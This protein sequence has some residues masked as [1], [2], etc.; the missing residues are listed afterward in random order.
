VQAPLIEIGLDD[1]V[2]LSL[3]QLPPRRDDHPEPRPKPEFFDH[4]ESVRLD[5]DPEVEMHFVGPLFRE[6]GYGEEHE[7][8]GF[9]FDMWEGVHHHT[10]EADLLYFAD[11]RHRLTNDEPA[12]S[13]TAKSGALRQLLPTPRRPCSRCR[14][15][16][17]WGPPHLPPYYPGASSTVTIRRLLR[18]QLRTKRNLL[19]GSDINVVI[20]LVS[21]LAYTGADFDRCAG[22]RHLEF[23][24]N[25]CLQLPS[26]SLHRWARVPHVGCLLMSGLPVPCSRT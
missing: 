13:G 7:G 21:N 22:A 8:A 9:P 12:A 20:E 16:R 6:L 15:W 19:P 3:T 14:S 10:A 25:G 26:G 23:R 18:L 5:S 17:S 24:G 4:L 2:V 11:D 1:W